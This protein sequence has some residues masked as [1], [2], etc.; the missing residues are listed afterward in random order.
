MLLNQIVTIN[1]EALVANAVS[2]ELMDNTEKN[3]QLCR[4]FVFNYD[5]DPKNNKSS[6]VG[7]LDAIRRS[8]HSPRG[9]A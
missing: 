7:V 5:S 9:Y 2:F 1:E 6:T 8:F 3:L 4:G